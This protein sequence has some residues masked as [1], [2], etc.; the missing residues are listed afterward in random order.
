M[1]YTELLDGFAAQLRREEKSRATA[2]KYVHDAAAFAAFAAGREI[3]KELTV[4]YKEQ[5]TQRYAP[6]SVNTVIASLNAFLRFCGRACCRVKPLRL[7]R[8]LFAREEKELTAAEYERLLAAAGDSRRCSARARCVSSF[9]P[10]PSAA[11]CGGI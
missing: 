2:E 6:G 3:T 4:A 10:A 5:L 7:Q 11:F 1:D 8:S 9:C